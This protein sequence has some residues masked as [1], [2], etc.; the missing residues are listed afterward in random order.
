MFTTADHTSTVASW[1]V[2][3]TLE[4]TP[5][6]RNR[7]V[8]VKVPQNRSQRTEPARLDPSVKKT[9]WTR[10]EEEM[11]VSDF[12]AHV[13]MYRDAL[14]MQASDSFGAGSEGIV[15]EWVSFAVPTSL[16]ISRQDYLKCCG[17][18]TAIV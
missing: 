16:N 7:L 2:S 11:C 1:E 8:W 10:E 18:C 13:W 5:A 15:A 14:R 9:E 4:R 17:S 12:T 6:L 3:G